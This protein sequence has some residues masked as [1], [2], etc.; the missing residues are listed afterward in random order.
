GVGYTYA[1]PQHL[2][3]SVRGLATNALN[4][5][6]ELRS[7]FV[8]VGVDVYNALG[9]TNADSSDV[10][11]SNWNLEPGQQAASLAVHSVAAP[12]TTVLGS[13]TFYL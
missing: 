6:G 8:A 4:I 2:S 5:G 11:V 1:S 7:R 13:V 3:D 12:P 10:Y 9:L